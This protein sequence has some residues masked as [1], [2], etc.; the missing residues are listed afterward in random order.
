MLEAASRCFRRATVLAPKEARPWIGLGLSETSPLA[1]LHCF[2]KAVEK[3]GGGVALCNLGLLCI[4][5]RRFDSAQ[6]VLL[7]AQCDDPSNEAMWAGLGM[8][9]QQ[10]RIAVLLL[11]CFSI[12]TQERLCVVP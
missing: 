4:Q 9:Y 5:L 10:V 2:A 8:I 7:Q 6:Q 12:A 3:G 11:P 1:A